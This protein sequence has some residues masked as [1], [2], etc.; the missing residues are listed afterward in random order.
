MPDLP[1]YLFQILLLPDVLNYTLKIL[2]FLFLQ[3]T[4]RAEQIPAM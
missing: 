4:P 1:L 2:G 3:L